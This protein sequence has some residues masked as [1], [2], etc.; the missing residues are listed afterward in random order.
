MDT[1]APPQPPAATTPSGLVEHFFRHETGRLHGA[2][3]RLLG[4]Q[5]IALAEDIAQEALLRALRT[6]SMGGIPVNPAAWI[7]RVARNLAKD[8]LRHR[9]M[10]AEKEPAIITHIEHTLPS[11][12]VAGETDHAIRDDAL[13]LLFVCCHPAVAPD[14]QAI[15]S[16]VGAMVIIVDFADRPPRGLTKDEAIETGQHTYR[17]V[18]TPHL[19]HGLDAGVLFEE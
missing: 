3:I 2:L 18:P 19:P 9:R 13:R 16:Q 4:V 5:N 15:C 17:F 10:S 8:H 12:A 11:P 1:P 14:A 7:T 6:W